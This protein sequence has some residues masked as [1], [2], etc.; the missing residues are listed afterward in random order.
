MNQI[1]PNLGDP[2]IRVEFEELSET[3][4]ENFAYFIWDKNQG[5]SL[6][7]SAYKKGK[8]TLV[9]ASQF[10]TALEKEL[11]S[12]KQAILGRT[13]TL[14]NSFQQKNPKFDKL[15]IPEKV[16]AVQRY[17]SEES[18][19]TLEQIIK[20]QIAQ[21]SAMLEAERVRA[22]NEQP[23]T[24]E[25]YRKTGEDAKD[26][27]ARLN[28]TA[29]DRF[30]AYVWFRD[31]GLNKLVGFM[32]MFNV[33]N[34]NDPAFAQWTKHAI[35][36]FKGSDYTDLYHE[37]WHEFVERYLTAP[38][39]LALSSTVKKREGGV[40]VNGT[41]IPHHK[42]TNRQIDE[43]L[44]EEFRAYALEE[45]RAAREFTPAV[46]GKDHSK[47]MFAKVWKSLKFLFGQQDP[48]T[49]KEITPEA[50]NL[51]KNL[52][53][54]N[55]KD[56]TPKEENIQNSILFRSSDFEVTLSNSDG[57]NDTLSFDA[58]YGHEILSA[59]DYL[60]ARELD[61]RKQSYEFLNDLRNKD[62]TIKEVYASVRNNLSAYYREADEALKGIENDPKLDAQSKQDLIEFYENKMTYLSW[63]FEGFD[64][65]I[66]KHQEMSKGGVFSTEAAAYDL[67][68]ILDNTSE[69]N[70]VRDTSVYG[71]RSLVNPLDLAEPEII[72]L[73]KSLPELLQEKDE[74]GN[75][76]VY[77]SP[78]LGLPQVG[79]FHKNKNMIQNKLNGLKSYDQIIEKL[80]ELSQI[81]PQIKYLLARLPKPGVMS[82]NELTLKNKFMQ[83][84]S[85]PYIPA[86]VV[87]SEVIS[88]GKK[89]EETLNSNVFYSDMSSENKVLEFFD[90][91]FQTKERKY[92]VNPKDS[93]GFYTFSLMQALEQYP[94][95]ALV[96]PSQQYAFLRD[97]F[98]IDLIQEGT[99]YALVFDSSGNVN[100]LKSSKLHSTTRQKAVKL[101]V[102]H[103]RSKMALFQ[104][105]NSSSDTGLKQLI[106]QEVTNPMSWFVSDI[107][108]KLNE[109]IL[110]L[111]N[112]NP[113]KVEYKKMFGKSFTINNE[114]KQLFFYIESFYN[115]V[116]SMSHLNPEDNLEY[117]VREWN[118][119]IDTLVD[120][121]S[122]ENVNE[123]MGNLSPGNLFIPRSLIFKTMFNAQG[124]RRTRDDGSSVQFDIFN[125]SGMSVGTKGKKTT[126]LTGDDKLIQDFLGWFNKGYI[127]NTRT[128]SKSTSNGIRLNKDFNYFPINTFRPQEA[129]ESEESVV[130]PPEFLEQMANY[131]LYEVERMYDDRERKTA[132]E[133]RGSEFIIF[134][135]ILENYPEI[136]AKVTELLQ[137]TTPE[138]FKKDLRKLVSSKSIGRQLDSAIEN[139]FTKVTRNYKNALVEVLAEGRSENLPKKLK[140]LFPKATEYTEDDIEVMVRHF[141][142]NYYVH[143]VEVLHIIYGDISNFSVKDKDFQANNFREVFKRLG[144]A[145]SPGKQP[146]IDK[147]D[148]VSRNSNS[149]LSRQLELEATGKVRE[150]DENFNYVQYQDVNSF[151]PLFDKT[152]PQGE[153][154]ELGQ[155]QK[156]LQDMYKEVQIE[157]YA[158]NLAAKDGKTLTVKNR[159]KYINQAELEIGKNLEDLFESNDKESD[160]QAI[161]NLDFYRYYSDLIA[162]WTPYQEQAYKTEVEIFK[163]IKQYRE[164]TGKAKATL[165]TQIEVLRGEADINPLPSLKL[166]FWGSPVENTKY[167]TLGK[168]SV[169]PLIPSVVFGT[170]LE[171]QM[172]EML[173]NGTDFITFDSGNKMSLPVPSITLYKQDGN[174]LRI[175]SITQDSVVKFPIKGL[176]RQQYMAPKFKGEATLSTQLV[177]LLF[178]NFYLD[179]DIN[180]E[181][182]E[183]GAMI[184]QLQDDFIKSTEL[185]VVTEKAK[186]FN[187]LNA[188]FVDGTLVS[189]DK[190][191]FKKWIFKEFDKKGVASNVYDYF[192]V[193][194]LDNK[195]VLPI[196]GSPQRSLI[197]SVIA[198]AISKKI[199]KPKLKGEAYVQTASTAH[200]RLG[201]RQFL[202]PTKSE[203]RKY[204]INGLR[205]YRVENG[206]TQPADIKIAFQAKK[207]KG[208]LKLD[209]KGTPVGTLERLN[210]ALMDDA[211]VE[212]HT[213]KLRIVGVRIP[214]QGFNS[215]EYFRVRQFL[216]ENAG[217]IIIVPFGI[218]TKSGSDFDNDKLFMYEPTIDHETGQLISSNLANQVVNGKTT[219]DH[220]VS[221][222]NKLNHWKELKNQFPE[223]QQYKEIQKELT[224]FKKI[225]AELNSLVLS[226]DENI[227][228][229]ISN[230]SLRIQLLKQRLNDSLVQYI[231][232]EN[233]PT[234]LKNLLD[235]VNNL[236]EFSKEL[237]SGKVKSV[238]T[239]NLIDTMARV[240]ST[241]ELFSA[242]TKKNDSTILKGISKQYN[243]LSNASTITSTSI[244]NPLTSIRIFVEN[245]LGK[246]S[247]GVDAK[248]NA[249]HK[250]FQ[251]TGLRLNLEMSS[252]YLLPSNRRNGE[253]ILGGYTDA[254]GRH[255]ISDIINEFINGHV[256]IEKEEWINFFN[257][258]TGRTPIIL[259]M[260]LNGTPIETALMLV[261][262]PIIQ[263]FVRDTQRGQIKKVLNGNKEPDKVY[264]EILVR[265]EKI[266][267]LPLVRDKK[268]GKVLIGPSFSNYLRDPYFGD[269]ITSLASKE[270]ITGHEYSVYTSTDREGFK[271]IVNDAEVQKTPEARAKL[272]AQ[273]AF[274]SQYYVT[275]E[276]NKVVREFTAA[277]D[278]NTSSYRTVNDFY[279]VDKAIKDAYDSFNAD[280]IDKIIGR[281][282]V[283]P[284][285]VTQTSL[286][287]YNQVFDFTGSPVYQTMVQNFVNRNGEY[288][289]DDQKT[290]EVNRLTNNFI[291]YIL[292]NYEPELYQGY[293]DTDWFKS[294][295][296]GNLKS[297]YLELKNSTDPQL[298]RFFNS[299]AVLNNTK[300]MDVKGMPGY[301]YPALATAEKDADTTSAFNYAFKEGLA[302]SKSDSDLSQKVKDYFEILSS[303]V[304][305]S[306][307]YNIKFKSMQPIIPLEALQ[308]S[309]LREHLEDFSK[310]EDVE[311][312]LDEFRKVHQKMNS[313]K[314]TPI[315][316]YFPNFKLKE[317]T[318]PLSEELD[319]DNPFVPEDE[320]KDSSE[321]STEVPTEENNELAGM[322]STARENLPLKGKGV[323]ELFKLNPELSKDDL[324]VEVIGCDL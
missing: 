249:L 202:K 1:C 190:A 61:K 221:L 238:A 50:N 43:I 235:Y 176:R 77:L 93:T 188:K 234:K 295:V 15:T 283:S 189:F 11:G 94:T 31:S 129:A 48:E 84:V 291:L 117:G 251:Q 98:G 323:S 300:F 136:Q 121:N 32:N 97:A 165:K 226:D 21:R 58:I 271:R 284:F 108:K 71:D 191:A 198:S 36:L 203:I 287:L 208:L 228:E 113:I 155:L 60:F 317:E 180:P 260:I 277:I 173:N 296:T 164:A 55:L 20:K 307:G 278:F 304:I 65:I 247:L 170:D 152:K 217:A 257:A 35:T 224:T 192:K 157:S 64:Q 181:F 233:T 104:L 131:F 105:I 239:N 30:E 250:L 293:R 193:S 288:W 149:Q 161:V 212:Q 101:A 220:L 231:D 143:Q 24:R 141:I 253:I 88:T 56:Y 162:E 137:T 163:L 106:S 147:S 99:P 207:H 139:Y 22:L 148:L 321:M 236:Q 269:H 57:S 87:K 200:S 115:L 316:K 123:L 276:Q 299:N 100:T 51:F 196:E 49:V 19:F 126:N 185:I 309:D 118:H 107:P 211:W 254:L 263:Y 314:A 17:L 133:V 286:E 201:S 89:G 37:A 72:E 174:N 289:T 313:F 320:D 142:S 83:F 183:L 210:E 2:K 187:K 140:Q 312:R 319:T 127:E 259:Q 80:E 79:N 75:P 199:L 311:A 230:V 34:L 274:L 280:G 23:I 153:Q 225:L 322:S 13:L 85:M 223:F 76:L 18:K 44:A 214:V 9:G 275:S 310:L 122:V 273:I 184:N 177:K 29:R 33:A 298:K 45:S 315:N 245:T 318:T 206:K 47:G 303:V 6:D 240:L 229:D 156:E 81:A 272:A 256:D 78:N 114:R 16:A 38:Q 68:E 268:T 12:R 305:F 116:N 297:L 222:T 242:F 132:K 261:N 159:Q 246:K 209:W 28:T 96:K 42:L 158:T 306:Q 168:Y 218:T 112:S 215:M 179:G 102:D 40:I 195:F 146:H 258:D 73:I 27:Q 4:G 125:F 70:Q 265:A 270:L 205:D 197:E 134:K 324:D 124:E 213:D 7:K 255:L 150:Y 172:F 232:G 25:N 8:E 219:S 103:A 204:G 262:Q 62:K 63:A 110:K 135:D 46:Q 14:V 308:I 227:Q 59:V 290:T 120:M 302:Y 144:S 244:F 109:A 86:I 294:S 53:V 292:H 241:A 160:S 92:R 52:Y 194:E 67:D 138:N 128:G 248:V 69:E 26:V 151:N 266:F 178:S 145:I 111:D 90:E 186:I 182:A 95:S 74:D 119:M 281:S 3:V 252:G 91:E 175:N 282:V 216:P 171:D 237:N 279:S 285:N 167:V 169:S 41:T 54:R 166:G 82:A 10:F 267:N 154:E 66:E 301:F 243:L 130:F 39:K 5:L 264:T